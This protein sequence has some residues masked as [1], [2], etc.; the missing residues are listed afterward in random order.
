MQLEGDVGGKKVIRKHREDTAVLDVLD[1]RELTDVDVV[2][3]V[4]NERR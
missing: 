2:G 3:R 4:T 1:E